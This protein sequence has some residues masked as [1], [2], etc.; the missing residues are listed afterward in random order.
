M[1]TIEG[2]TRPFSGLL[3]APAGRGLLLRLYLVESSE[4]D[5]EL[6]RCITMGVVFVPSWRYVWNKEA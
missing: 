4:E 5:R 6:R 1:Y 3:V 2:G